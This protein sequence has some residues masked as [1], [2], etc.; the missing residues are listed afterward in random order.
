MKPEQGN[1]MA[2]EIKYKLFKG[3]CLIRV[4][5]DSLTDLRRVW[6]FQP[7]FNFRVK[8]LQYMNF[9]VVY[10]FLLRC[11]QEVK[12]LQPLA[13]GNLFSIKVS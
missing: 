11:Q 10:I 2:T 6:E 13:S 7:F 8:I 4:Q 5:N 9:Q 3:K 1:F 12:G